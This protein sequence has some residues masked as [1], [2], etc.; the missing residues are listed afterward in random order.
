[1]TKI[2]F[3]QLIILSLSVFVNSGCSHTAK[4]PESHLKVST[5]EISSAKTAVNL[6]QQSN[7]ELDPY[8]Q[9]ALGYAIYPSV[10]RFGFGVG[11]AYGSGLVFENQQVVGR[12]QLWQFMYGV[13]AGGQYYSKIIFFKD[14]DAL[15]AFKEGSFEF[16]GNAGAALLTLGGSSM[17]GFS[18]GVAVFTHNK[19]GL[20]L[21]LTPGGM[22]FIYEPLQNTADT[23]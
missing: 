19:F 8:F 21:E 4:Q 16:V 1:M 12:T 22:G 20:I 3:Y 10:I 5:T 14:E 9:K 6:F 13:L 17:P 23:D 18:S 7:P 15:K 11:G 2:F